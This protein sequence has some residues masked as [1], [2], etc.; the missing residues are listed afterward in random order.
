MC[1]LE[2]NTLSSLFSSGSA[3]SILY[4]LP[5]IQK[6]DFVSKFQFRPIFA[7]Y[8]N[9]SFKLAEFLV[10]TL[11]PYASNDHTLE[12]SASF[13]SQLEQFNNTYSLFMSSFD[14]YFVKFDIL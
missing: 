14:I 1:S 4:G 7:A 12:N 8:N 3:T 10:P 2:Q 5:E 11:Q 6:P 9:P 13:V